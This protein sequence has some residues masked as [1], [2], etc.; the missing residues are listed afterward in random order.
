MQSKVAGN[1]E[2]CIA[3]KEEP[4]AQ[5]NAAALS[6]KSWFIAKAP[7]PTF[8]RSTTAIT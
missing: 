1:P 4:R 2:D 7:M 8:E 6:F 3:Y 5:S